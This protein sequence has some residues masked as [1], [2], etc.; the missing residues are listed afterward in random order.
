MDRII[1]WFARNG[2]AANLLMALLLLGGGLAAT[3]IVQENFPEFSLDAVEVRVRY[4]GA[5]PEDVEDAIIRRIEDRVEAVEGIDRILATA[6]E[7]VGV[8]TVELYRGTNLDRARTDIKSEVDRITSF[9]DEA[10]EPVVTE[11]TNREQVLQVALH[12][13]A[14]LRVLR[15]ATQQAEDAL[16][17]TPEVS[18]VRMDGVPDEELSIEVSRNALRAHGLTLGEMSRRVREGSLDLPGGSIETTGEEIT[19]R[20]EGQNYT[21]KEF[22]NIVLLSRSD[23]T[24]VRLGDV[25]T[26]VDGFDQ[27]S[28]LITRFD[29]KPAVL[30]NVF[31]T[32]DEQALSVEE[33]VKSYLDAELRP[34]LP[35]GIEATIWRNSAD[36]LRTRLDIMIENGL[37]GLVLVLLVLGLFLTPRKAFWTASG[38]FLSFLGALILMELLDVSINMLSVFGFII[39]MGIAVDDAI[40]V[41]ENVYTEQDRH[42]EPLAA[43]IRGTQRVA[44][45]VVF[46][47]LTTMAAFSPLL[48]V[49][50]TI[51]KFL[52]D[53]PTVVIFILAMSVLEV[54]FILPAHLSHSSGSEAPTT[55]IGTVLGRVRTWIGDRLSAF[56]EGPL[57]RAL[58]FV[59][60]HY[61]VA[62]SGGL[63]LL[64]ITF[65]LLANGYIKNEFFPSIP[66]NVVTAQLEMPPGTNAAATERMARRLRA[67]G[68]EALRDLEAQSGERL[69]QTTYTTVGRQPVASGGRTQAGFT[70]QR[71][72]VA[73]VSLEMVDAEERTVPSPRL[74]D[75]WRRAVGP[76][77]GIQSLAFTSSAGGPGGDPVSVK[78]FA[79]TVEQMTRAAAVVQDSLH[80]YGGVLDVTSDWEEKREL[81][82]RLKPAARSLGLTLDDLARQT[83]AAFFGIESYRLQRG[84]DEVRVYVRLSG[85]QR[86]AVEDLHEYRI[87]TP[88]GDAVPLDEVATVSLGTSPTQIQRQDGRRVVTVSA[89]V[90][91][92]LTTG[93]E[94]S[95]QLEQ[96]ALSALQA[97]M[98]QL[99]YQFGGQQRE[100]RKAQ[101]SLQIGF[102]LALFAIYGLLAIPFRSYVQ[103]LIIMATIPFAW[104]GALLGHFVLG[105]NLIVPSI[106][107]IVGLSGVIVNDALVMLDFANEERDKGASW[108]DALIHAG[109]VR[110]RPI[111]LTSLTTFFGLAPFILERSVE[112][113][114]LVPM[115]ISLGAGILL[116][117]AILM[118]LVP[119]LAMLQHDATQWVTS[120][121]S[122]RSSGSAGASE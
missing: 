97:R 110:F 74:E 81:E 51:G 21:K 100:Q 73:E 109:Q 44:T 122:G 10:E 31:R 8:V 76:P 36:N 27:N 63:A 11:V 106:F 68:L 61:G 95:A 71:P 40:V 84:Q 104:I 25:A 82:L 107:G 90:N 14:P 83:R 5:S 3:T 53:V 38:I 9:P 50:G 75:R 24:N 86:N 79:P 39:A 62:I 88:Q 80:R 57:E 89:D 30:L 6:A 66:G 45:P 105:Y 58:T 43:A 111:L 26:V 2:V 91:A 4:P 78:L 59:T 60:R 87:R 67:Q 118:L 64:I 15:E 99:E 121:F 117:T 48:F 42:G 56:I 115:A 18:Y 85:D 16:A 116:G 32:G 114:F 112:A 108:R 113:Q 55:W 35:P 69:L 72:N 28:D 103:P 33:T 49:G 1:D 34:S 94:A 96:G 12:G 7:N 77:G 17:L 120:S 23:G 22:E 52:G 20:T 41:V 101:G 46:A 92:A 19:I 119:A 102:L 93:G 13:D 70:A 54:L 98:P 47:V 37:L 29:G 65:G